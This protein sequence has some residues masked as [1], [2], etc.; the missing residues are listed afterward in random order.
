VSGFEAHASPRRPALVF[1]LTFTAPAAAGQSTPPAGPFAAL[2]DR[3][4]SGDYAVLLRSIRTRDDYMNI[5]SDVFTAV[6]KWKTDWQRRHVAFL[7]DLSMLGLLHEWYSPVDSLSAGRNLLRGRPARA[8]TSADEDRFEAT[9]HKAAVALLLAASYPDAADDYLDSLRDRG[10]P[11]GTPSTKDK[12]V[13][14]RL[15][16]QRAMAAEIRTRP[17]LGITG[18][19]TRRLEATLTLY[20]ISIRK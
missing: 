17:V 1:A 16:L 2:Y 13:E 19:T 14:P 12:L 5:R 4:A 8:G 7:L 15:T 6:G 11:E 3:Y 20:E 18:S 10:I 9:Y